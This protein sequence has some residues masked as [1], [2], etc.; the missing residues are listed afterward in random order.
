MTAWRGVVV[1]GLRPRALCKRQSR[2]FP[3]FVNRTGIASSLFVFALDLIPVVP[4]NCAFGSPATA[5]FSKGHASLHGS[6]ET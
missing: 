5:K 6:S 2:R 3:Y 1:E 4:A